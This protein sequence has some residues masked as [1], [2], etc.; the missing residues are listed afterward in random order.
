MLEIREL[1]IKAVVNEG[2]ELRNTDIPTEIT[3]AKIAD[4]I[5]SAIKKTKER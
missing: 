5:Q 3:A 2:K 1:V 4:Q